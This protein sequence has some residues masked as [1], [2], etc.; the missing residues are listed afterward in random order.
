MKKRAPERTKAYE[1]H[2]VRPL[3]WASWINMMARCYRKTNIAYPRYGGAGI[4]VCRKWHK[5]LGFWEDMQEGYSKGLSL[6]RINNSKGYFLKKLSVGGCFNSK[7]QPK[8]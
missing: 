7:Q 4:K 8:I 3:G 2:R 5:F 6:D 1:I